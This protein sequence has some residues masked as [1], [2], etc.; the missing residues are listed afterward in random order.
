MTISEGIQFFLEDRVNKGCAPTTCQTYRYQLH[1]F[2]EWCLANAVLEFPALRERHLEDYLSDMRVRPN[3]KW[4]GMVSPVTIRKRAIGLRTFLLFAKQ[5]RWLRQNLAKRVVIPRNGRRSA[6]AL[7]PHKVVQFLEVSRWQTDGHVLRDYAMIVLML[8]SGL[9]LAE[10]VQ[11]QIGDVDF[12][13]GV[14]HVRHGKGDNER[15]TVIL[16]STAELL[17]GY[18]GIRYELAENSQS[19]LFLSP[20]GESTTRRQVY[21]AIKRRAKQTGMEREVSPHK[22]RHTWLTEYLNAGGKIHTAKELAGHRFV[23]TTIGYARTVAIV[24]VQQEHWRYSAVRDLAGMSAIM[25]MI[26]PTT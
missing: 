21:L 26:D 17:R 24:P 22:L 18:L 8:D 4:Q 14:I 10:V 3:L 6:K 11:L 25:K 12:A 5:K 7:A 16:N 2:G 20:W 15:F 9:R 23:E 13:R 1:L 19:P